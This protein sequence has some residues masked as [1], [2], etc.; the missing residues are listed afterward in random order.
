M[1][2]ERF[3]A[4]NSI[5]QGITEKLDPKISGCHTP[6]MFYRACFAEWL[7]KLALSNGAKMLSFGPE[8]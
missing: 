8:R 4:L 2:H 5:L 1:S 3:M 6:R 7:K